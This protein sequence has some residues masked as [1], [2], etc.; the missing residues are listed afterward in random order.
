MMVLP[1]TRAVGRRLV[2]R[3]DLPDDGAQASTMHPLCDLDQLSSI[4]FDEKEHRASGIRLGLGR[5]GD[6]HQ[7][8]AGYAPDREIS[9]RCPL[10]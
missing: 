7:R 6:R 8:S 9:G 5:A 4:R 1:F 3:P 10:R 2:Q